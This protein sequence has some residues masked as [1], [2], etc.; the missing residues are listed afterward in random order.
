MADWWAEH[1]AGHPLLDLPAVWRADRSQPG[2]GMEIIAEKV[3]FLG[4]WAPL[5]ASMSIS[6]VGMGP[7]KAGSC[8]VREQ[9][10]THHWVYAGSQHPAAE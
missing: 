7:T 2:K 10:V 5:C 6:A 4:S 1:G 8:Y 3:N 9:W